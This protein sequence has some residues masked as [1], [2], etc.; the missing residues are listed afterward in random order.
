M[1]L[2]TRDL[3]EQKKQSLFSATRQ[4]LYVEMQEHSKQILNTIVI[5][6]LFQAQSYSSEVQDFF[7]RQSHKIPGGF[8]LEKNRR[9]LHFQARKRTSAVQSRFIA[10]KGDR[11]P[12]EHNDEF[13]WSG[14]RPCYESKRSRNQNPLKPCATTSNTTLPS[15]QAFYFILS[16]L[17][18]PF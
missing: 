6:V 11:H 7:F 10:S 13:I 9:G 5:P 18:T 8:S 4:G 16:K 17:Q 12:A 14:E 2:C 1:I 3:N 15:S